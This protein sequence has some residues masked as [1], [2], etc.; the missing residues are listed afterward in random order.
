MLTSSSRFAYLSLLSCLVGALLF[1]ACK[2][3]NT[4][5]KQFTDHREAQA[6]LDEASI[7]KFLADS[8]I[9]NYTR[10][11]SGLFVQ[12][13]GEGTG[14]VLASGQRVEVQYIG[15]TLNDGQLGPIFDSSYENRT[16]CQCIRAVVGAGGFV[17][18]FNEALTLMKV[19]TRQRVFIPS[20]LGYGS[21]LSGDSPSNIPPNIGNDK[22]LVFDMTVTRLA[23]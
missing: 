5:T 10:T 19:G 17:A 23:R 14:D 16:P 12:P 4:F 13:L 15:R 3:N 8:G 9:T 21:A 1:S 2:G 6:L 7:Q 11:E 22:V 18:G 20:R